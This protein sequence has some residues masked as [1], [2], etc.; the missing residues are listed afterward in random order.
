MASRVRLSRPSTRRAGWLI[1]EAQAMG[2]Q[3]V[4][5]LFEQ[6]LEQ[7]QHTLEDV[8]DAMRRITQETA[9]RVI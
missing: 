8:K 5:A 2:K 7:E 4:V 3:S 6:N 1:C 9:Q